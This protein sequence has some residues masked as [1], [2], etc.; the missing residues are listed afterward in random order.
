MLH[1]CRFNKVTDVEATREGLAI[2]LAVALRTG[3]V[4]DSGIEP[5]FNNID[6]PTKIKGRYNDVFAA[7]DERNS[8]LNKASV[9]ANNNAGVGGEDENE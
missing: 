8:V 1:I 9:H 5:E 6:D 7:I 2:D 3:V 4:K